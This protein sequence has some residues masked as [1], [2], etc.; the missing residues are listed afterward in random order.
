MLPQSDLSESDRTRRMRLD[1]RIDVFDPELPFGR[2]IRSVCF[3]HHTSVSVGRKPAKHFEPS[4]EVVGC[5]EVCEVGSP[6]I[7]ALVVEPFHCWVLDRSV[8]RST[9][10]FVQRWFGLASRCSIPFASQI[11]SKSI[12]Q[13]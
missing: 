2:P 11:M 10:P 8:I 1:D 3:A 7:V 13:E 5:H 4:C 9:S 12:G 6:L